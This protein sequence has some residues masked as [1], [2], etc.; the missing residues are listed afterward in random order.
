MGKGLLG[1][2]SQPSRFDSRSRIQHGIIEGFLTPRA[3]EASGGELRIAREG[4]L[5][6]RG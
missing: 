1:F 6:F 5:Y 4:H 2:G 3:V